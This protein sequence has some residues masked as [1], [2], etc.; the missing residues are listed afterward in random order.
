MGIWSLADFR[1]ARDWRFVEHSL[2]YRFKSVLNKETAGQKELFF[3]SVQEASAALNELP[4]EQIVYKPKVDRFFQDE[5][6]L[7]YVTNLFLFSGLVHWIDSQGV[8]TLN[9]FPSTNGGRFFT[10][11]IGETEAAFSSIPK[12]DRPQINMLLVDKLNLDFPEIKKWL[13]TRNGFIDTDSYKKALPRACALFFEGSFGEI[14][15][16]FELA[17]IRRALIAYWYEAILSLNDKNQLS[18]YE[19]YHNYNATAKLIRSLNINR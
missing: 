16:L 13:K 7:E 9:L 17:G 4:E 2:H 19:R 6:L 15:K 5:N 10:I 12:K 14:K 3:L 18:I 8:W 1:Q 11:N